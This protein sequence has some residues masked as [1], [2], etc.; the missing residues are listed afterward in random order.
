MN[1]PPQDEPE[2]REL[3]DLLIAISV[4]AR[5]LARRLEEQTERKTHSYPHSQHRLFR[6][7][8]CT[9][10]PVP[11]VHQFSGIYHGINLPNQ[12]ADQ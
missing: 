2:A 10:P 6:H 1:E 9:V 12:P 5:H 3:T 7:L 11:S 4:V 8:S